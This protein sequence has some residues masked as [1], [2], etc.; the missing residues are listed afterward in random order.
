[1]KLDFEVENSD[2]LEIWVDGWQLP[3]PAPTTIPNRYELEYSFS[4][5]GI[6]EMVVIAFSNNQPTAYRILTV[7]IP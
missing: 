5:S 3:Q 4:L 1:M 6:R 2:E 7:S